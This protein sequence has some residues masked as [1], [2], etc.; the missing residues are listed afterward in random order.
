MLVRDRM[1]SNPATVRPNSDPMAAQTLLRYGKFGRLAVVD[2]DGKL[3]GI[4]TA[5]DL[6]LF[7]ST[8]PSPGV[9]RR[10]FRVDQVMKSPVLTVSPDYPLE[11]AA[12]LM[13]EHKIGGLPVMEDEKVVGI[14]TTSD[15]FAQLVEGLGGDTGSLRVTVQV[16]D[17]P[18]QFARVAVR[19][20]EL[21]CNISSVVSA[22]V[23]DNVNLT[24]RLE[25]ADRDTITQ[26]IQ[27]L[28]GI[29]L[30][31]IWQS[32]DPDE[33]AVQVQRWFPTP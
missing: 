25:D 26:A 27:D 21:N 24:M 33:H 17:R 22:R 18:G 32:V 19:M 7:F 2:E 29:Q 28:D 23:G 5:S 9:I 20:A 8:A 16:A 4:I 30:I 13:L 6:E 11:E 12:L 10:Q 3:A 1:T 14:I 31:H 15:I